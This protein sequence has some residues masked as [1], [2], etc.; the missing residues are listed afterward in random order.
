MPKSWTFWLNAHD[1]NWVDSTGR[2]N[3]ALLDGS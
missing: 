3:T 2:R 1:V